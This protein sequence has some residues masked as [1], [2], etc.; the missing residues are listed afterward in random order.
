MRRDAFRREE[1]GSII[2]YSVQLRD[3]KAFTYLF[4]IS[5]KWKDIYFF[6]IIFLLLS[7]YNLLRIIKYIRKRLIMGLNRRL[8]LI[9]L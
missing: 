2:A 7:H 3:F 6:H 5:Y 9:S 8:L 1:N 4:F